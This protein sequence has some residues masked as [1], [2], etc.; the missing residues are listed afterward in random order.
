M[1]SFKGLL[2]TAPEKDIPTLE[3]LAALPSM[4][5]RVILGG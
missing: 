5:S 3:V 2:E 4:N 1:L